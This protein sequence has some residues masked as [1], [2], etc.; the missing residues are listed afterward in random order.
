MEFG[1]RAALTGLLAEIDQATGATAAAPLVD[2]GALA[3]R[4]RADVKTDL[5]QWR[6][7]HKL[8]VGE[9]G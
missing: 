9:R 1:D 4:T 7:T 3:G 8:V 6:Q 2:G 5:A